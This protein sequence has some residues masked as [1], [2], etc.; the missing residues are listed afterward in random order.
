MKIPEINIFKVH[1]ELTT[2]SAPLLCTCIDVHGNFARY[3]IKFVLDE[4]EYCGLVYEILC[5]QLARHLN[6]NTPEIAFALAGNI[7]ENNE[8]VN[9]NY[10]LNA[11]SICFASK[12]IDPHK[13]ISDGDEIKDRT[14][15]NKFLDPEQFFKIALFDLWVAHDDRNG[16]NYN[17]L[18]EIS[19]VGYH[20]YSIDHYHCFGGVAHFNKDFSGLGVS[21]YKSIMTSTFGLSIRKYLQ[22][23]HFFDNIV[24]RFNN[25][26]LKKI[27]KIVENVF[28]QLPR[29]WNIDPNLQGIIIGV[30]TN[31]NRNKRVIE[32][33]NHLITT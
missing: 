27:K 21:Q 18:A 11:E 32:I 16:S 6:L 12:E 25:I 17:L 10:L 7:V 31:K 3:Y 30:L 8:N 28:S 4:N 14:T 9:R 15:F 26:D 23:H 24:E 22:N 29:E 13:M 19:T 20:L 33:F 5:S 1:N 2:A